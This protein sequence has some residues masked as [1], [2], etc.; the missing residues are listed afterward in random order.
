MKIKVDVCD[1]C[2]QPAGIALRSKDGKHGIC[3]NCVKLHLAAIINP[4]HPMIPCEEEQELQCNFCETTFAAGEIFM[5][6]LNSGALICGNCILEAARQMGN[7]EVRWV[8]RD[9]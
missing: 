7:L 8:S 4:R 5:G 3:G 9:C 1:N 6:E 2:R